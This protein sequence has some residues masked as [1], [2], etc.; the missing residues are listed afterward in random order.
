LKVD[1]GN[2][3]I[4]AYGGEEAIGTKGDGR[5]RASESKRLVGAGERGKQV[6]RIGRSLVRTRRSRE[7]EYADCET[8]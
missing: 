1:E 6:E 8:R 5:G 2:P 3:G 7:R 4:V